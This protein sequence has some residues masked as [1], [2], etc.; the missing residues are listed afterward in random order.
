LKDVSSNEELSIV[1]RLR[2]EEHIYLSLKCYSR[3]TY[4]GEGKVALK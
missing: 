1:G 4:E 2:P 3:S